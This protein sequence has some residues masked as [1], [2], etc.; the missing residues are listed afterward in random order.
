MTLIFNLFV[1]LQIFNFINARKIE[2]EIN[3]LEGLTK[4]HWFVGIN[5]LIVFLQYAIVRF[6]A[7]AMSTCSGV[8][9]FSEI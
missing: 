7:K 4:S 8:R 3:V 1:F 5:M 2:D 6:G 9:F